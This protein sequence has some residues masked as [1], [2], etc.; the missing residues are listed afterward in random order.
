M[1]VLILGGGGLGTVYAGYLARAGAAVTLLV[2]PSQA[3]RFEQQ[4]VTISGLAA[5]SAPVE[6]VSS[7]EGLGRFD[8]L[9]VCVKGRDTE[10]ALASVRSVDVEATISLQNGV[11]KDELLAQTFGRAHVL[12]AVSMVGGTLQRPGRAFHSLAM[13]TY[14]GEL[15]GSRSP[16]GERLAAVLREA[17]LPAACVPDI[18]TR[19]W[20][21]LT[22]F[23]RTALLAAIA[24]LDIATVLL[25]PELVPL[26]ARIVKEVTAVAAAEGHP[27]E[28][29]TDGIAGDPRRPEAALIEDFQRDGHAFRAQGPPVYPSMAQDMIAGRPTEVEDTAGD[30][31]LRAARHG[32]ATPVLDTCVRLVR[33]LERSGATD[34]RA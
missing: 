16:R 15:D 6:V 9:F 31:L 27:L 28:S 32:I 12:G 1:R 2:K 30:V 29:L 24:R 23:L 7:A 14:L 21:K 25:D 13:A 22:L 26:C 19:E 18:V 10:A 3:D 33:A 17:G 8:Y 20:D 4:A 11:R 34:R 5:F